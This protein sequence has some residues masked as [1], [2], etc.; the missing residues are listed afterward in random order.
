MN[1]GVEKQGDMYFVFEEETDYNVAVFGSEQ[2]AIDYARKLE[3]ET[4]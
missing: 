1:Y 3:E 4:E 2:D